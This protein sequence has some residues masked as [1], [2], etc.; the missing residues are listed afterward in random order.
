MSGAPRIDEDRCS[1]CGVLLEV[2]HV[3]GHGQCAH[4]GTN[5]DP[6]CSGASAADEVGA[7]GGNGCVL[8]PDLLPRLFDQLGGRT[9]T[10]TESSLVLALAQALDVGLD[11]AKM[12][13][14]T[15]QELGAVV[16]DRGTA[17]LP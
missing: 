5:V 7:T 14:R 11:E 2:V 6:C 1:F 3:H 9:R 12:V 16:L 10:L 15:A 17:R 4:C 8:A 13:L